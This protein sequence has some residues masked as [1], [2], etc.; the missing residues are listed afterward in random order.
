MKI[1]RAF[2]KGTNWALAG[3]ISLLGFSGCDKMGSGSGSVEYGTPKADYTVKGSVVNKAT[4][5]PIE[6]IQVTYDP[7]PVAIPMYG[8]IP[9]PYEPK[10]A[11]TTDNKGEFK[12]TGYAFPL[13]M[14]SS[15]T[16]VYVHDIDG[17]KNGLFK[18]DTLQ[19]DF[20]KAERTKKPQG[21]WYEGE[22]TVTV[23]VEL[24]E[25]KDE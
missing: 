19:I 9:A 24:T 4:G 2:I 15:Q 10:A 18:S 11:V 6:G 1:N 13:S 17:E 3:L 7:G 14:Q 16:P 12:L 21:G 5:K 22:Y 20:S 8:V 25:I 23:K